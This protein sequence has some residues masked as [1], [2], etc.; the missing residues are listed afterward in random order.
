[1]QP[2]PLV[3]LSSHILVSILLAGC[4]SEKNPT[5]PLVK[6]PPPITRVTF[7]GKESSDLRADV[8]FLHGLGGDGSTTWECAVNPDFFWPAE[9]AKKYPDVG[10]WSI[11][12]AASPSEWLGTSMPIED[13]SQNLLTLLHAKRIGQRPLIFIAHS[14]GGLVVKQMIRDAHGMNHSEWTPILENTKGVVFLATP[15]QGSELAMANYL[16]SIARIANFSVSVEQLQPHSSMLRN[17][18]TWYRNNVEPLNLATKVYFENQKYMGL[19]VVDATTADPGIAGSNPIAI[20]ANHVTIAKPCSEQEIVYLDVCDFIE[21]VLA[22]APQHDDITFPVFMERYE[23][24]REDDNA[25]S[26]FALEHAGRRVKWEA[27]V[28][29]KV[30]GEPSYLTISPVGVHEPESHS[31]RA[32]FQVEDFEVAATL[33]PADQIVVEG[34]ISQGLGPAVKNIFDCRIVG[35]PK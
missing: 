5:K 3:I 12:Y 21:K 20:D 34:T 18:N 19:T 29:K 4:S 15:H 33:Q 7:F 23:K 35:R 11:T 2:N 17:L 32:Y 26:D 1:M 16:G 10:V 8:V 31:L 27:V 9:L 30:R 28:L 25:M 14:L 24:Q 22:L 13:R 6:P